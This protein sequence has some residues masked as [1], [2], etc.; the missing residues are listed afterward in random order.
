MPVRLP[1]KLL[2]DIKSWAAVYRNEHELVGMTR[3]VAIRCLILLGLERP[4]YLAVD[5]KSE[6]T[7][8]GAT[9][10]LL[11]FYGR[12]KVGKWLQEGT[13]KTAKLKP[14]AN[15][16]SGKRATSETAVQAA[17]DRAE[18]RSKART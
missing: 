9:E 12:G 15:S 7:F 17:A 13:G 14:V 11:K 8:E 2:R 10:P 5:P 1:A 4:N 16:S 3:S 18:R 6:I